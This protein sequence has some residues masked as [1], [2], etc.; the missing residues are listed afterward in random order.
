MC[1]SS[2]RSRS[3]ATLGVMQT[4]RLYKPMPHNAGFLEI[5][6]SGRQFVGQIRAVQQRLRND[7]CFPVVRWAS[8]PVDSG[9][10]LL[11]V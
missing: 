2:A 1:G 3:A 9:L 10:I 8:E 7:E 4:F 6:H 5:E 11:L